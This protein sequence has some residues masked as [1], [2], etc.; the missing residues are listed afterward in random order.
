MSVGS[1]GVRRWAAMAGHS[2]RGLALVMPT[3]VHLIHA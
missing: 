2:V 1:D 3:A